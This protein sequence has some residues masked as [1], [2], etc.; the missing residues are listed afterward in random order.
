MLLAL[1]CVL[2]VGVLA[3]GMLESQFRSYVLDSQEK[4]NRQISDLIGGQYRQDGTWDG[5]SLAVIGMNAL[6]RGVIVRVIGREGATVWDAM[7][8]NSGLCEQMIRHMARNMESRYRNWRGGYA[9]SR[10]PV[11]SGLGEVGSVSIGFYGPFFF[12]DE[13]LS[14]INALNRLLLWVALVSLALALAVG[15]LMAR[16]I[17]R[18]IGRVVA[19]TQEM[20]AGNLDTSLPEKTRVREIDRLTAAVNE[21]ARTLRAQQT[22]RKRLTTDV[23]HE[24]RTPLATLQSHLEAL[25]D[26]IW[27]P[28]PGR[29][30]G[31]HDETLRMSR[32][33]AD[34]ENLAR[35]DSGSLSLARAETDVGALVGRIVRNHQPQFSQKGVH[36]G[37]AH[38]GA[39]VSAWLDAD[40]A[41]QAVVN[42]LSN[43]LKFTPHGS[44]VEVHVA[45]VQSGVEIRVKDT[46]IGIAAADL[47]LVF[48]RLYRA[49]SSRSRSTG[50]TGIGLSIT[51]AIVEAHGGTISAVSEPG[52]GSEFTI[53]F[54]GK[55]R[56]A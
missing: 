1:L 41:S 54:P 26:G 7:E 12:N 5:A 36:L 28:D 20:A 49:D 42:L 25:L 56:G 24:L 55:A 4:R 38:D 21:L 45:G 52:R 18:P 29:L 13:D 11:R 33:V 40:K 6:E 46:G 19:A 2:L 35:Y 17:S 9:E 43:A 48:E 53:F 3:N 37:L 50:G 15:L 10:Y 14:F 31:L 23:A 30:A 39:V 51:R 34:M 22:L 32:L 47:P 44:T 8:H 16:G 27:E